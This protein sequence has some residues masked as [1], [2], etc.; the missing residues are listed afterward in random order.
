MNRIF[1]LLLTL[2]AFQVS[3]QDYHFALNPNIDT[4]QETNRLLIEKLETF[5]STKNQDLRKNELWKAQDFEEFQYPYR[6]IYY[7]EKGWSQKHNYNPTLLAIL[8][9]EIKD[10]YILK[11]GFMEPQDTDVA[12]LRAI[13]NIV[14]EVRSGEVIFSRYVNYATRNWRKEKVGEVTYYTS[15]HRQFSNEEANAQQEFIQLLCNFLN[16]DEIPITYYSC[17]DPVELFNIKGFDYTYEMFFSK[18]GGLA[19]FNN[20]LYSG[21]NSDRYDHEVV[22]LYLSASL[23]TKLNSLLNEGIATYL[24]GSS[25]IDY[26]THRSNLMKYV[27]ENPDLDLSEHLNPYGRLYIYEDT[28]VPYV[29]G[30]LLCEM[31]LKKG[32]KELLF[33]L[34]TETENGQVFEKLGL[35]SHT[36]DQKLKD[37][38]KSRPF[39]PY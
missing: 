34:L 19:G 2:C 11:F 13:Y 9:A 12:H 16:T 4:N 5:L 23:G 24:G 37:L 38:L 14:A 21:N 28:S 33:Q 3:A 1:I 39:L 18:T 8:P 7:I 29:I 26:Q 6:D 27:R 36:L 22:H 10:H 20:H 25:G 32:G 31:A 30:G 35:Q 17:I 15:P